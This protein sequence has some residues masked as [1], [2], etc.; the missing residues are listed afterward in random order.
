MK[1][2]HQQ[3]IES[4]ALTGLQLNAAKCEIMM[5]DFSLIDSMEVFREFIRIPKE[6]MTLLG[7]LILQGPALDK[8]LK[9][10]VEDLD[11]AVSRLKLLNAHDALELLKNSLSMPRQLYIWRTSDFHCHPLLVKFDDT[12]SAGFSSILNVDFNDT[13]WIQA[14]LPVK[15][16]RY[17]L[18]E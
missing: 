8:A 16:W 7:A 12:L 4:E 15:K 17:W 9:T 6:E 11:R 1:K 13:Q 14:T 18:Q 10:K 5:D 2:R 3:I